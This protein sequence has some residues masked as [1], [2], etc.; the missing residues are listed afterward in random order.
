MN[1]QSTSD[2]PAPVRFPELIF[3]LVGPIGV[4]M[5]SM[6]RVIQECLSEVLYESVEIKLTQEMEPFGEEEKSL[7]DRGKFEEYWHKMNFANQIRKNL[8]EDALARI[9]IDAIRR[10]RI[11]ILE[12]K[13]NDDPNSRHFPL[14]RVA[15]VIRQ[16]KH[17]SEISLLRRVYARQFILVSGYATEVS[18]MDRLIDEVKISEPTQSRYSEIEYKARKLIERDASEVGEGSGQQLRDTFHLADVFIDGISYDKMKSEMT[19]F[20]RA[21]FGSSTIT[22]RKTEYGMYTAKSASLRSGD[23]SRQV[24]AA[25]FTSEG[26]LVAQ[27]CN[28]VPKAGGGTYWEDDEPDNRD[29]RKGHDPNEKQKKEL[30]RDLV[31]RLRE[32]GH[33]SN[34]LKTIGTDTAIVEYLTKKGSGPNKKSG[35]LSESWLMDLTEYG[36]V[37]HAEMCA[38]CD[39]AR[40]GKRLKGTTL[41]CT[42]FPC[43]NCTKH[44]IAAGIS[45]VVYMEP[46][47]NQKPRNFTAM[48]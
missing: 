34:E 19:R 31:E 17:P 32:A 44:V 3:G 43:H 46:Y 29:F 33:L 16:F 23:L 37:V 20:I 30:L 42:T 14:E 12:T 47:P 22:P 18:R 27:E 4:D 8:G 45:K 9:A 6:S 1:G 41:F 36:R 39:A 11:S 38:I 2:V 5:T 28:E 15:Y 26:E 25:I 35:C 40:L 13:A 10:K 7:G 24:G 48:K 21:L